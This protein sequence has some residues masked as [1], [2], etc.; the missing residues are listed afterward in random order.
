MTEGFFTFKTEKQGDKEF[1]TLLVKRPG[2]AWQ[3][4][5][6]YEGRPTLEE[7]EDQLAVITEKTGVET[8]TA[9]SHPIAT[10]VVPGI[11]SSFFLTLATKEEAPDALICSTALQMFKSLPDW[12]AEVYDRKQAGEGDDLR[13]VY[14]VRLTFQRVAE[15][16]G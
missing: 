13:F 6:H 8:W 16:V 11:P 5:G 3:R 9:V 10:S 14:T 7:I 2:F 4:F 15:D 12:T 1:E